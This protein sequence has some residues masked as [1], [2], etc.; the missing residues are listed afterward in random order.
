MRRPSQQ[1]GEEGI[2]LRQKIAALRAFKKAMSALIGADMMG[3]RI[4]IEFYYGKKK[5]TSGSVDFYTTL[6]VRVWHAEHGKTN[7]LP[8]E[9]TT[10]HRFL[11][12]PF[13]GEN[14]VLTPFYETIEV[15][16]A[17]DTIRL[18]I[19]EKYNV[20]PDYLSRAWQQWTK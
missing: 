12:D 9:I 13:E 20:S 14:H 10:I 16:D 5:G 2:P 7:Y 11:P 1:Q 8:H 18:G 6:K 4:C 17:M 15:G 19:A 3:R